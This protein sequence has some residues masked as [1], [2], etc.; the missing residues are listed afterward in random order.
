MISVLIPIYNYDTFPLVK[1]IHT[2]LIESEVVFEIICIDDASRVEFTK[3]NNA[4]TTLSFSKLEIL[5]Q[6]IGRSKIRNSLATS[7]KYDWLLFLDTDVLPE[8]SNFINNYLEAI[9]EENSVVC[10][11]I[12]YQI[13]KPNNEKILHWVY[14]KNREET[15]LSI[16]N[17][18]PYNHFFSANF[19]IHKKIFSAIKFNKTLTK[20]GHEDTLFALDLKK[21]KMNI[22][23]VDNSVFHRGLETDTIFIKKTKDSIENAFYL[24]QKKLIVKND[25]RLIDAFIRL[26]SLKMVNLF[27]YFY[28]ILHKKLEINLRSEKPSLFLFD[29]YKLG[30]L[31][32]ISISG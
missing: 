12:K 25:L 3:N 11:G 26:K 14:G 6:N 21:K 7:A 10:G 22:K 18:K 24:Y 27:T 8:K 28:K 19:L 1:E 30:Y 23:H 29:I 9:S 5:E 13:E 32:S 15:S 17:N 16:R 31:C 4:I 2:Q 20:Y